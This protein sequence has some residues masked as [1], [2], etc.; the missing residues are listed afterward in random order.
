MRDF[1][2]LK[3]MVSIHAPSGNEGAMTR[4]ILKYIDQNKVNWKVMPEVIFGD[5][6]QDCIILKFGQPRTAI[7]A[8]LDSI[9]FTAK[10]GKELIKIGGPA[11]EDGFKLCG[12]DDKGYFE[13]ELVVLED[14]DGYTKLEHL[15]EREIERGTDL[16]FLPEWREDDDFIQCCYMDN[17]LG[18]W[19]ALKVAE[20]LEN[21]VICFSTYEEHKGGSVGFLARHIYENWGVKQALISDITWV[22]EGVKH[23]EGV[24][25]SRRDSGVPRRSYVDR[26]INLAKE[27]G[28]P[29]QIEVESAGGSDGNQLQASPYP[30]DWCF[31]G[32]PEDHVHT[33]NEKVHKVDI[34]TMIKLYEH[35]M[36]NL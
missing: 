27:S 12:T 5:D 25:I 36:R 32:A 34:E 4:F 11:T 18:V 16:T 9:G 7:F 23:A 6:H 24:A 35:L 31:I 8:H 1:S 30:F 10:Y 21:G 2:L 17:R 33:P 28:I 26:I 19:V 14:E 22:T 15:L 3:E 29:F 13:T 20:T